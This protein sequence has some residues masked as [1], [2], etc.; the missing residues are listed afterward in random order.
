MVS[1]LIIAVVAFNVDACCKLPK[2]LPDPPCV[3]S[4]WSSWSN[5][6]IQSCTSHH[7]ENPFPRRVSCLWSN[8]RTERCERPK[9]IPISCRYTRSYHSAKCGQPT[10]QRR[11]RQNTNA[12]CSTYNSFDKHVMNEVRLCLPPPPTTT[13]TS[14]TIN[15]NLTGYLISSNKVIQRYFHDDT[16]TGIKDWD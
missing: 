11:T 8:G 2:L 5:S 7:P 10:W 14:T 13:A 4:Q 16:F 15:G 9:P 1:I 3:L 12:P 6:G